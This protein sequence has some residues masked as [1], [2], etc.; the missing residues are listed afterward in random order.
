MTQ[1]GQVFMKLWSSRVSRCQKPASSR[2]YRLAV[3]SSPL[4]TLLVDDMMLP[5]RLLKT[6]VSAAFA[7]L[8]I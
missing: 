5:S 4:L 2:H 3:L 7:Q 1:T 6:S 8:D